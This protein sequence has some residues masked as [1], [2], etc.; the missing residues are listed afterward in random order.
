VRDE[1][2]FTGG[3]VVFVVGEQKLAFSSCFHS[4]HNLA[5]RLAQQLAFISQ[6]KLAFGILQTKLSSGP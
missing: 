6:S 2:L 3:K 5:F 1:L 4:E